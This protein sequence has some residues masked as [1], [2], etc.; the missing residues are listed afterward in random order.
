MHYTG[1]CVI[2]ALSAASATTYYKEQFGADWAD[3]WVVSSDWKPAA[4]MGEWKH[5]AGEFYLDES[6]KGI[7][8]GDDARFYGI[9]SKMDSAFDNEGKDLIIQFTVKHEQD[10]DC[11][12]AYIKLLPGT[13]DQAKFGGDTEYAIMFGPDICGYTKRT[14]VIFTYKGENLLKSSEIKC[15]SDTYTH[16]YTL[17]VKA[18]NTYTVKIDNEETASGNLADDWEFL[19]PKE[20]KDP[21]QSKPSDWVDERRIPDPEETKPEGYDDIPEM[22]PEEGAE[23]PDDWDEED[24]G[25][26]EPPMISNP[27]YKG[28]WRPTMIDN[29]AY[30]GEWEHPM[31]ANPDFVEDDTLYNVCKGGCTTVGFELWQVKAGTVFD[32]IIVTDSVAEAEAMVASFEAKQQAEKD[33]EQKKK[34]AEQA[35][36]DAAAAA[37]EAEKDDDED[38]DED[39]LEAELHEEL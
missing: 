7:Q 5:T 32:D 33:M 15:E 21:A 20:I 25:E 12:G 14:H 22:I 13:V 35:A 28:E 17:I 36:A 19:E 23:M 38:E 26:W 39:D 8:T 16:L 29:P 27:D 24:D 37:A 10:I 31:I 6:D 3:N 18:D 34:D 11:G 9:S 2:A 30:K 4:E 1:F